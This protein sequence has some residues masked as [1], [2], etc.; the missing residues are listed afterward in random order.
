MEHKKDNSSDKQS[1]DGIDVDFL[2]PKYSIENIKDEVLITN[3]GLKK[4]VKLGLTDYVKSLP[5]C[6]DSKFVDEMVIDCIKYHP[7]YYLLT[8]SLYEQ[9]SLKDR[10]IPFSNQTLPKKR[11]TNTNIWTYAFSEYDYFKHN[12]DE[13]EV[14]DSG[15]ILECSNCNGKGENECSTCM[16][17]GRCRDC[18]GRGEVRCPRGECFGGTCISCAG[19]GSQRCSGCDGKG[20]DRNSG[21]GLCSICKGSGRRKCNTCYGSGA[22]KICN[23]SGFLRCYFC[24]GSG[25][26]KTCD[27]TGKIICLRC[28]G[29]GKLYRWLAVEQYY[30]HHHV[31]NTVTNNNLPNTIQKNDNLTTEVFTFK[32]GRFIKETELVGIYSIQK[33]YLDTHESVKLSPDIFNNAPWEEC[34]TIFKDSIISSQSDYSSDTKLR[35]NKVTVAVLD[36]YKV[37]YSYK[38]KGYTAYFIGP[39]LEYYYSDSDPI[40]EY[41]VS[42]ETLANEF[43]KENNFTEAHNT[44]TI[45]QKFHHLNTNENR[46][47]KIK[48]RAIL[49]FIYGGIISIAIWDLFVTA[50][51]SMFWTQ[52]VGLIF[53]SVLAK[54]TWKQI[55]SNKLKLFLGFIIILIVNYLHSPIYKAIYHRPGFNLETL[56]L[57]KKGIRN[58]GFHPDVTSVVISQTYL[59]DSFIV[60]QLGDYGLLKGSQIRFIGDE[61]ISQLFVNEERIITCNL[62]N[63]SIQLSNLK[64]IAST[65]I[66]SISSSMD[67]HKIIVSDGDKFA[68]RHLETTN[69]DPISGVRTFSRFNTSE[70]LKIGS[71][72]EEKILFEL[73]R[74]IVYDDQWTLEYFGNLALSNNERVLVSNYGWLRNGKYSDKSVLEF[75]DIKNSKF[76]GKIEYNFG[77]LCYS[78]D[79][80]PDSKSLAC[81]TTPK[82]GIVLFD[83]ATKSVVKTLDNTEFNKNYYYDSGLA[84]E[85]LLKFSPDGKRLI[86]GSTQ[87]EIVVWDV[88]SGKIINEMLGHKDKIISLSFSKDGKYLVSADQD[89]IVKVWLFKGI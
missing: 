14:H 62:L 29:Q 53:I 75:V 69:I 67:T 6:E 66:F 1:F 19:S 44:I 34:S 88:M 80:S 77:G 17:G 24:S 70:I 74:Q 36:A 76:D 85:F 64:K 57:N 10:E 26:C 2:H 37:N 78:M 54:K 33:R 7:T 47:K 89:N 12:Y 48:S 16:G 55:R 39:K 30:N 31:V 58:V 60:W 15:Y 56:N 18:E 52:V 13:I 4:S 84:A 73:K 45:L 8:D 65:K 40:K 83:V 63:G 20:S 41:I 9:R 68:L 27:G 42:L 32:E 28:V 50:S 87:G 3:E 25:A 35:K 72:K 81:F 46:L 38:K 49:R 21:D 43:E 59:E 23:G 5:E 79:F 82:E 86:G 71:L 51:V 61:S 22:C 11:I